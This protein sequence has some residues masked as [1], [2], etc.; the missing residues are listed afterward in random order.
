MPPLNTLSR[1]ALTVAISKAL[2]INPTH[3]ATITVNNNG[4]DGMGCT[5]REAVE[6][7][8]AEGV[9]S[10]GCTNSSIDGFGTNNTIDFSVTGTINLTQAEQL[11][12]V[13]TDLLV[14]GPGQSNLTIDGNDNAR[15]FNIADADVTIDGVT[16]SGGATNSS[17]GGVYASYFS[18]ASLTNST[19]SGN[20]A[21]N[22]GG[23]T[24]ANGGIVSL[25]NTTVS[26]NSA[27][28]NGGGLYVDDD[29]GAFGYNSTVS[30]VNSTVSDNTASRSGGGIAANDNSS[31]SLV[32]STVSDNTA[33]PSGG[34]VSANDNSSISLSNS[35]VSGNTASRYGGGIFTDN[36]SS[37]SLANSTVSD[38]S[39]PT[40]GGGISAND[41]S[42]VSLSNSTVTGNSSNSGGGAFAVKDTIVTL[43][44]STFSGN[45]AYTYGGGLFVGSQNTNATL[46]NCTVS[47][48]SSGRDGGGIFSTGSTST[49]S[50]IN[51]TV[52]NNS[53]A[54]S[55]GGII[56]FIESNA[57]LSN[58]L[59][60]GNSAAR[61]GDEVVNFISTINANDN[62]LFGDDG[63]TN[64]EA[65]YGFTPGL[66]D[67][68]ATSDG[69]TP[70]S[71]D[72]ILLPL[73]DNGG[74][75]QTHA[76]APESPARDAGALANCPMNDQRGQLRD[77]GDGACDI[78][79]IEFNLDDIP[80]ENDGDFFV[81]P[82][83]N[84]KAVVVP[85]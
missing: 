41:G 78:G 57:Q 81:I 46:A 66:G 73:A 54:R 4:D 37:V 33:S 52:A 51:S 27:S 1:S 56:V 80:E 68:T 21:A 31:I 12:I 59:I 82:L 30:L 7:M 79:A 85:N 70:T 3:A 39:A 43:T 28:N 26:G 47:G 29:D 61:A 25:E 38:N 32:N 23:V 11:L 63:S 42:S 53:A 83:K 24:V 74:D 36:G 13:D 72:Q 44:G 9:G 69:T 6:S 84:G 49:I 18:S 77:D 14:K 15:V 22:G 20:V 2:L 8:V 40:H 45:S 48:N 67:V 19:V 17:G 10:T 5:L 34:G 71:L 75:T 60:S 58:S 50:L 65:F 35:N 62:N 55:G 16:I 76:L 64:T